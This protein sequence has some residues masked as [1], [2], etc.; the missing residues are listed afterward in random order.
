MKII[1]EKC[2]PTVGVVR[3]QVSNIVNSLYIEVEEICIIC[4][5]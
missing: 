4:S 5:I 2:V 1:I 3:F